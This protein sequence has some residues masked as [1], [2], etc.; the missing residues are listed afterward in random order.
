[1]KAVVPGRLDLRLGTSMLIANAS[2]L[3]ECP[4]LG[5]QCN[6]PVAPVPYNHQ[7]D[8]FLAEI[9]LDGAYGINE[10][11]A[12]ELRFALRIADINPTYSEVDG[13]PK[14]VPDDIHHHDETLVGP[15]DPWVLLRFAAATGALSTAARL[16][17]SLPLGRIEPDPYELG[18]RGESHEHTQFGTGT[19][20]PLVGLGL[21]YTVDPVELSVSALGQFSVYENRYGFRAP[22]R[23]LGGFRTTALLL[24]GAVR[25]YATFDVA[26]ETEEI[27]NGKPGLEGSN[28]RTD[29]LVGAG[30][31]WTFT[32]PWFV[33]VSLRGRVA[34]IAEG[35]S[36]DYP[37]I[38]QLGLGTSYDF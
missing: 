12:A 38:L 6:D 31:A 26:H 25:P 24:D 15:S 8:L 32:D 16:G 17:V 28:V 33:D 19:L 34:K 18:A 1:V 7:V 3:A 5:P 21:G 30:I 9:S 2:H 23:L 4:D 22:T 13:T 37:G 14:D 27:W 36:F 29:F 35:A 10:W 20:V 11:L